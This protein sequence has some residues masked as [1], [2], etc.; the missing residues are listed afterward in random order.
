MDNANEEVETQKM[1]IVRFAK[2]VALLAGSK[3]KL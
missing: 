3:E 2:D 1:S